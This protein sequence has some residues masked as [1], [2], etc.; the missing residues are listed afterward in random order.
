MRKSIL[1]IAALIAATFANAQIN[2]VHT[3]EGQVSPL[4]GYGF[5]EETSYLCSTNKENNTISIFDSNFS[6]Y[7]TVSINTPN[8]YTF[9]GYSLAYYN[10]FSINKI[11]FI[12]QFT[13]LSNL[14]TN[15]WQK[16]MIIDE[17]AN[18]LY[19]FGS[20]YQ[21]VAN[22][23]YMN[24]SWYLLLHIY[25]WNE[26]HTSVNIKKTEI[27]SLPGNGEAQ[28]VSTPSSPKRSARKIAR[29]GQVLVQTD[30]NTYT[31]TG[32]EVK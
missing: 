4:T 19:D 2:L 3:F 24:G 29:D 16:I 10:I 17:D 23:F 8:G 26:E 22:S 7:K 18:V 21:G 28:A 9:T 31:L 12:V 6:L 13:N 1:I 32:A 5:L 14:N 27:Y 20:M 11:G 30:T 15:E 25:L